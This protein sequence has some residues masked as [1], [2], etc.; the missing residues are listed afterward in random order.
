MSKDGGVCACMYAYV[1]P[2]MRAYVYVC[3]CVCE[4]L[5]V[6]LW[7]RL[8]VRQIMCVYAYLSVLVFAWAWLWPS[9]WSDH[10]LWAFLY[11]CVCSCICNLTTLL[12]NQLAYMARGLNS[13]LWFMVIHESI[14]RKKGYS[15]IFKS[16]C[17]PLVSKKS[18]LESQN[19][20]EKQKI[21]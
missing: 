15:Q 7:V 21:Q 8:C 1:C 3:V 4:R 12:S 20:P 14:C 6:C 2:C 9:T 5:L 18:F 16:I 13:K 11:A 17:G 19:W 10:V